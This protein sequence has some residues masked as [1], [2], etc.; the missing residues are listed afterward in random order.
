VAVDKQTWHSLEVRV[1]QALSEE[2]AACCFAAGSCGLQVE[3]GEQHRLLAYFDAALDLPAT[4]AQLAGELRR[5]GLDPACMAWGQVVEEEWDHEWRRFFQ[6]VWATPRILVHPPWIPAQ[7]QAGQIAIAIEPKMAFGTGTH[8]S[9]QLCLLAVDELLQP[10]E[11][12]LDLGT[13][14]GILA[15]AA[16]RLG[17]AEVLAVDVDPKALENAQEYLEAN[18]VAD[19]VRLLAGSADV[20]A[21]ELFDLVLANIQSQTLYP[22]LEP[23]LRLLHPGAVA[24]FCGLL[25]GERGEFCARMEAAG[26]ETERA[27]TR[28]EWLAVAGRRPR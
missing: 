10:G 21:G 13:G 8:A 23:I 7:I 16:A 11:R 20:V 17:A 14:S 9:T 15:I 18:R 27:Y 28:E 3:E 19:R 26:F 4:A 1:P 22:L 24:V 6:P 2:I 12:C 5:R 25:A